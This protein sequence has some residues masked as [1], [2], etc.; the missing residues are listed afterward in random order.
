MTKRGAALVITLVMAI[1]PA[2]AA[3]PTGT[4]HYYE[5]LGS[6]GPC[7]VGVNLAVR[8]HRD[9]VAAHYFYARTL[10]DIPLAGGIAG[11]HVTLREAGGGLFDLHFE[12]NDG[13]AQHP[14]DVQTSTGLV[15]TWSGKGRVLPV[16]LEFDTIDGRQGA[17]RY[18]DV[19]DA[20]AP[21]FEALVRRFLHGA[22]TG[23]RPETVAA[24]SFPLTIHAAKTYVV[25]DRAQLLAR[26]PRIFTSCFI[27]ALRTA[28]PH[29]MFVRNGSAMVS[30]GAA[31]FD[32]RGAFS[33]NLPD[34][35][36]G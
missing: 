7:R 10:V 28:V 17:D 16:R 11:E 32:A 14:L 20:P 35:R 22:I 33:L 25:P 13:T 36:S 29:E 6:V 5:L 31:W 34:C 30:N 4:V 26:W 21:V 12:T 3:V 19:T 27:A 2:S 23:N 9:L 1:L 8:D 24:V 15:G 18:R